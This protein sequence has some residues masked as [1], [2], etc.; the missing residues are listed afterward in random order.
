LVRDSDLGYDF[1]ARKSGE[2]SISRHGKV[3]TTLR[4]EAAARFLVKVETGGA[5]QVMARATGNY[6]RGSERS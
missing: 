5:Q 2:V 6:K 4:G 3:V 1:I